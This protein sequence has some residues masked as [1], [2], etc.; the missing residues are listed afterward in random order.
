MGTKCNIYQLDA[1]QYHTS[2]IGLA[3]EQKPI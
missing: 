3:D 1:E 2:D